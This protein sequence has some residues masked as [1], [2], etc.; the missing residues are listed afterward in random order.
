MGVSSGGTVG[1][2]SLRSQISSM[3]WIGYTHHI[4]LSRSSTDFYIK[5][6]H[7]VQEF[8]I[9]QRLEVIL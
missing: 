6:L 3:Q 8:N 5:E 4:F 9:A 7:W 2:G 1:R